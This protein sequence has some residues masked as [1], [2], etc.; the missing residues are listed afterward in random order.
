M[1][2][3]WPER[4]GR[5]QIIRVAEMYSSRGYAHVEYMS[6]LGSTDKHS[7]RDCLHLCIAPGVSDA[8][9]LATL[10]GLVPP[11]P[12]EALGR[13]IAVVLRSK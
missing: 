12:N 1:Q 11:E 6:E 8:L 4:L 10:A 3:A 13:S 9:A 2:R 5:L 7:Q